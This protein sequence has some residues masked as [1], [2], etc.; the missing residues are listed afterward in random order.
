MH[1]TINDFY[2]VFWIKMTCV[3]ACFNCVLSLFSVHITDP[4]DLN[5]NLGAG[6]SRKSMII[7]VILSVF[8]CLLLSRCC[9]AAVF[10]SFLFKCIFLSSHVSF[11]IKQW[12]TSSW[13]LSSMAEQCLAHQS[14]PFLLCTPVRWSV[15]TATFMHIL[16]ELLSIENMICFHLP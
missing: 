3:V 13:R 12:L 9:C 5:H 8:I 15:F 14:K 16:V 4:F 6:L 2:F 11:V 10:F 7:Y 1:I